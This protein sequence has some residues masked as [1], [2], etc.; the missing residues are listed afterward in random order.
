MIDARARLHARDA[1][2]ARRLRAP[3]HACDASPH[4]PRAEPIP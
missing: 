3:T 2:K 1:M 4:D